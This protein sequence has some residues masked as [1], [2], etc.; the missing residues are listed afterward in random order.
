MV[1]AG[2]GVGSSLTTFGADWAE[3]G[4]DLGDFFVVGVGEVAKIG[5]FHDNCLSY[6]VGASGSSIIIES[7][8]FKST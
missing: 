4:L 7:G 3:D 6:S 5:S 2:L 1:G 8:L